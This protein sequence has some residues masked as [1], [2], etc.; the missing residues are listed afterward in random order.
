[1]WDIAE[2]LSR[3]ALRLSSLA[4]HTPGHKSHHTL[5]KYK[6]LGAKLTE[7][8]ICP[9]FFTWLT[10]GWTKKTLIIAKQDIE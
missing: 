10:K 6:A 8:W 7:T 9:V 4:A 2:K 1:M 3:L 5:R